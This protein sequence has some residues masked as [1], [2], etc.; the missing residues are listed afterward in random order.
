MPRRAKPIRSRPGTPEPSVR[1]AVAAAVGDGLDRRETRAQIVL[2][3][4]RAHRDAGGRPMSR[5]HAI[6]ACHWQPDGGVRVKIDGW[7][8]T[9][10][11]RG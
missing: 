11:A 9:V 4:L 2:R 5:L 7:D 3:V 8:H 6:Q 10:P 1:S